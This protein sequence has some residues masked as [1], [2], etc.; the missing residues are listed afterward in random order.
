MSVPI[1]QTRPGLGDPISNKGNWIIAN[2]RSRF[3]TTGSVIACWIIRS[4][5]A[6][7]RTCRQLDG[8][9]IPGTDVLSVGGVCAA[10]R[11]CLSASSLPI[12]PA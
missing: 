11:A 7:G 10:S 8:K 2:T 5:S 4:R 6:S 1:R 3:A 9:G 12:T